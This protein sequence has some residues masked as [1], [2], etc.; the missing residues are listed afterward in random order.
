MVGLDRN[1]YLEEIKQFLKYVDLR[2]DVVNIKPQLNELT[3]FFKNAALKFDV[4]KKTQ[5]L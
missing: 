3:Q 5:L 4:K 1:S 2:F